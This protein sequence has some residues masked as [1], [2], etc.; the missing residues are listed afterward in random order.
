MKMRQEVIQ[1]PMAKCSNC[2]SPIVR[3]GD[4]LVCSKCGL[5]VNTLSINI[6]PPSQSYTIQKDSNYGSVIIGKGTLKNISLL[7]RNL[8]SRGRKEGELKWLIDKICDKFHLGPSVK[9]NSHMIGLNL[10][11]ASQHNHE[12]LNQ[13]AIATYSVVTV[14]RSYGLN[15]APHYKII[16]TYLQSIGFKVKTK[17]ILQVIFLAKEIG[18]TEIKNDVGKTVSEIISTMTNNDKLRVLG[19]EGKANFINHLKSISARILNDLKAKHYYFRSKNPMICAASIIYAASKEASSV[20]NIRNPITQR[21]LAECIG[22]AEY[23]V[24]ETYEELFGK[25]S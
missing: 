3:S 7:Q 16:K 17:D 5:V 20:L 9:S 22:Y 11:H 18:F 21:E 13:A 19:P 23:S 12:R 1:D 25:T 2:N 15:I 4:E 14:T 10:L 6:N 24:R 8:S